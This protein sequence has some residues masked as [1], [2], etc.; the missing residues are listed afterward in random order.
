M[1][2]HIDVTACL[3]AF[4]NIMEHGKKNDDGIYGFEGLHAQSQ[5][6]GYTIHIW[7]DQCDL[8]IMFHNKYSLNAPDRDAQEAFIKHL[9]RIANG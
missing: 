7:N 4:A 1:D 6:D 3:H 2:K 9:Y 8:V 5:D